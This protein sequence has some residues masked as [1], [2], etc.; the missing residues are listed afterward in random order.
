M[1][2]K[3]RRFEEI[4][5]KHGGN[6]SRIA[7][8]LDVN[9]LTVYRWMESDDRFRAII[10]E[11]RGRLLD[12]CIETAAT[13]SNGIPIRDDY[14]EVIGWKE[15]PDSWMLRYLISTLGRKEG[16]GDS[17]DV[18]TQGESIKSEPLMIE[19]IDRREQVEED[20]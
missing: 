13:I 15:R 12:R 17:I 2:P 20:N 3:L 7:D 14:G 9:R 5:A 19:V 4:A 16:F 18:T 10:E 6:I 8:E 1:K 11:H